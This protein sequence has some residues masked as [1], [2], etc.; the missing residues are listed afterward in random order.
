MTFSLGPTC[1]VLKP[2]PIWSPVKFVYFNVHV[3]EKK[4]CNLNELPTGLEPDF[5]EIGIE[6]DRQTWSSLKTFIGPIDGSTPDVF[7]D[8]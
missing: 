2:S 6:P 7:H 1:G 8:F 4:G 5:L 3:H